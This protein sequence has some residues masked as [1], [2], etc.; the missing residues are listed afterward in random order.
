MYILAG[1]V[2][3][4]PYVKR[5]EVLLGRRDDDFDAAVCLTAV[6]GQV[7]RDRGQVAHTLRI[8]LAAGDGAGH[9]GEGGGSARGGRSGLGRAPDGRPF[10]FAPNVVD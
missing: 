2:F 5:D 7:R 1:C 4:V 3:Y 6:F 8:K 10:A 9:G